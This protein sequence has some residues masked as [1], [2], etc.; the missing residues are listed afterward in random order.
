MDLFTAL[1]TFVAVVDKGSFAAAA[2][3]L[4]MSR[5]MATKHVADLEAHLNAKLL[6]RTTRRLSLT[7]TGADFV[8]RSQEILDLLDEAEGTARATTAQP[9]GVLRVSAPMSFGILH[10]AAAVCAYQQAFPAVT[11]ELSL[12]DRLVDLVEEGFDLALRIA[13]LKDSSLKARFLAPSRIV[14]AA[15]P[16]YITRHGRPDHP[17]ALKEHACL[18]YTYAVARDVWQFERDGSVVAVKVAGP[19]HSNNGDVLMR[20]AI[21]GMGIVNLPTFIVSGALRSGALQLVLPDWRLAQLG[22]YAVWPPSRH[23]SAKVRTF[24]DCLVEHFRAA[25]YWDQ[26]IPLPS[27]VGEDHSA[28]AGEQPVEAHA[29][30]HGEDEQPGLHLAESHAGQR[31]TGTVADETPA[32]AEE[33]R[34][35]NEAAIDRQLRRQGEALGKER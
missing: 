35:A 5:A 1:R 9:S 15:S 27:Q 24:I 17:A 2:L 3:S 4:R 32:K 14:V 19:L 12:N 28:A 11:V 31:R 21:D 7:E 6:H 34:T 10:L 33:D 8:R 30:Q 20:A 13:T 16:A 29:G 22:I 25:P 26:G 23:L 18:L